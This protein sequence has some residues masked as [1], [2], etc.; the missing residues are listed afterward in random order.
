MGGNHSVTATDGS[1]ILVAPRLNIVGWKCQGNRNHKGSRSVPDDV[2]SISSGDEVTVEVVYKVN[3]VNED[4][5]FELM[6]GNNQGRISNAQFQLNG[7]NNNNNNNNNRKKHSSRPY[8]YDSYEIHDET[9]GDTY[10]LDKG[11]EYGVGHIQNGD[12]VEVQEFMGQDRN[13]NNRNDQTPRYFEGYVIDVNGDT[14]TVKYGDGGDIEDFIT[15]D[16]I[17]VLQTAGGAGVHS[18]ASAQLDDVPVFLNVDSSKKEDYYRNGKRKHDSK[19]K[20][21]DDEFRDYPDDSNDN[22]SKNDSS[23]SRRSSDNSNSRESN[24]ITTPTS[25]PASRPSSS[26][27]PDSRVFSNH[28][29]NGDDD[30]D[31]SSKSKN[32]VSTSMRN[33]TGNGNSGGGTTKSYA[34]K[35]NDDDNNNDNKKNNNKSAGSVTAN[36]NSNSNSNRRSSSSS[37]PRR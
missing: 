32:A 1:S 28:D 18:Y 35:N 11:T 27:R 12:R 37:S 4:G 15:S 21:N 16:R 10:N 9:M 2:R 36:S 26:P 14:F 33:S 20:G 19:L 23:S 34:G 13:K 29:D 6:Y 22:D 30:N 3:Q 8:E 31:R 25:R 17:R 24:D 5:S 7:N